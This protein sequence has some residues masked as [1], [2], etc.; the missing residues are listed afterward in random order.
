MK[1]LVRIVQPHEE[2]PDSP[3][4]D[5]HE[6]VCLGERVKA[7]RLGRG[8][9]RMYMANWSKWVCNNPDCFAFAF[10]SDDLALEAIKE[11]ESS[12]PERPCLHRQT[13]VDMGN[14]VRYCSECGQPARLFSVEE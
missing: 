10:V 6:W 2:R 5:Y 1:V 13:Y 12:L 7:D 11:A 14:G 4:G 9:P 3:F 8:N